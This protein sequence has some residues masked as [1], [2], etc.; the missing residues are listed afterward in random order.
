M[1]FYSLKIVN[2]HL[3]L[4]MKGLGKKTPLMEMNGNYRFFTKLKT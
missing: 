1:L 2:F 4:L 3:F